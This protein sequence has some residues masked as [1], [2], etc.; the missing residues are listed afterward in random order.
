MEPASV[1]PVHEQIAA[2]DQ[3]VLFTIH[4]TH[5]PNSFDQIPR[6][7]M[8]LP[9]WILLFSMITSRKLKIPFAAGIQFV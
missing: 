2:L 4:K 9:L 7:W 1:R 6:A 8:Q 5:N 3:Q